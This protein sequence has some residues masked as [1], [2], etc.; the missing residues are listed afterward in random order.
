M[1]PKTWR[2]ILTKSNRFHLNE[3]FKDLAKPSY[4]GHVDDPSLAIVIGKVKDHTEPP[5]P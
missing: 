3:A 2:H 1:D 5:P 4:R